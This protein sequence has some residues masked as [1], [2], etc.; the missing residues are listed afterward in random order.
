M[1]WYQIMLLQMGRG[2]WYSGED[3]C[4]VESFMLRTRSMCFCW[5]RTSCEYQRKKIMS[6]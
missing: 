4:C 5:L 1:D 3:V 6:S 2:R